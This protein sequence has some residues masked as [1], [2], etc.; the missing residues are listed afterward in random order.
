MLAWIP[1][2]V[3]FVV[4]LGVGGK[5]LVSIPVTASTPPSTASIMSF[6]SALA[7]T[8]VSWS[9]ISPDY[10]IFHDSK[11]SGCVTAYVTVAYKN[12]NP[13]THDMIV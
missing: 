10:G 13:L 12:L 6:A 3:A 9:T 5:T 1:N 11:A 7:T 4:M 8:V 2:V